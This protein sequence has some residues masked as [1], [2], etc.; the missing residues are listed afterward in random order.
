MVRLG[1]FKQ[2]LGRKTMQEAVVVGSLVMTAGVMLM[3]IGKTLAPAVAFLD[4]IVQTLGGVLLLLVP[5]ILLATFLRTQQDNTQPGEHS[6][7][8]SRRL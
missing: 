6:P 3:V 7:E 4:L 8:P 1:V 5:L 2:Q